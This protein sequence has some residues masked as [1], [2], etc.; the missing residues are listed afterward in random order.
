MHR[1]SMYILQNVGGIVSVHQLIQIK[2][3]NHLALS[4][5]ARPSERHPESGTWECWKMRKECPDVHPLAKYDLRSK[6]NKQF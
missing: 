2:G 1:R 3:H 5:I 4:E 6:T